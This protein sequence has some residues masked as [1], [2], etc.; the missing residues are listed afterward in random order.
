M[1]TPSPPRSTTSSQTSVTASTAPSFWSPFRHPVYR[2]IWF[3]TVVANTGTW[4]YNAA[5]G[6]LHGESS[7]SALLV[8]LVQVRQ[9]LADVSVPLPAGALADIIDKRRFVLALEILIAV[10]SAVFAALVSLITPA[11]AGPMARLIFT[12]TLLGRWR[13]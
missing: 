5:A 9:Q 11:S 13:G 2:S 3:A 8:S 4:M 7:P 6:W 12:P 1:D 10:V